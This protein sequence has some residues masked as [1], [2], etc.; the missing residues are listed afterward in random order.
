MIADDVLS[1]LS[2]RELKQRHMIGGSRIAQIEQ[3]HGKT[4][5]PGNFHKGHSD[6]EIEQEYFA[7]GNNA[8]KT[9]T[10]LRICRATVSD[11]VERQRKL[12]RSSD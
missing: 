3:E 12:K 1:G 11:A 9:A 10:A 2:H 5:R 8:R 6:A 7:N 4:R